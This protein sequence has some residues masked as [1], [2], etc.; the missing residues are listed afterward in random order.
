MYRLQLIPLIPECLRELSLCFGVY[1][2]SMTRS[3]VICGKK[4]NSDY[5]NSSF[6]FPL[7]VHVVDYY[8]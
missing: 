6:F 4:A 5:F 1:K 7:E 3:L 8:M 2:Y